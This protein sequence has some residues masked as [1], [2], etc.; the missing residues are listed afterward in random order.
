MINFIKME[1]SIDSLVVINPRAFSLISGMTKITVQKRII[2]TKNHSNR[3]KNIVKTF[4]QIT[5]ILITNFCDRY[6][7][8]TF[9]V[10]TTAPTPYYGLSRLA[11]VIYRIVK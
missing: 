1:N 7:N 6:L 2:L 10:N 4:D 5:L 11:K 3:Y 9:K 8:I